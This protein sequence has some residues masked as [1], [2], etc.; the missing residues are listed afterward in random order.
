MVFFGIIAVVLFAI[1]GPY[2]FIWALNTL[3]NLHIVFNFYTWLA[4]LIILAVLVAPRMG[5]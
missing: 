4:A 5:K 1:I 3:F 2:L